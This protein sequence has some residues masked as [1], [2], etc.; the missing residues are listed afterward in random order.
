MSDVLGKAA[1]SVRNSLF[2]QAMFGLLYAIVIP[3]I[4]IRDRKSV[5]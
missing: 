3:L 1:V 4:S 2:D 5:V